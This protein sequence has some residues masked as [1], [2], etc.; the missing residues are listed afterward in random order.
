MRRLASSLLVAVAACLGAL[1]CHRETSPEPAPPADPEV[2]AVYADGSVAPEDRR[3]VAPQG[4]QRKI[5]AADVDR[6][7]LAIPAGQ[8]RLAERKTAQWYEELIRRLV[9]DRLLVEEAK[10]IGIHEEPEFLAMRDE[11]RRQVV[12]DAYLAS[13]RP[14]PEPITG[15]DLRRYFEEHRSDYAQ[16]RRR[17]VRHLFRR[18]DDGASLVQLKQEA[19]EL[20]QRVLAGES[21]GQLAREH[22]DSES[23]HNEGTLGWVTPGT[24]P[25][26]LDEVLF[27]LPERVPSEPL[28]TAEGV[29]L[30]LV[31]KAV[32]AK[33]YS[34]DE[35][36]TLILRELETERDDQ[37]MARLV[38][39]MPLPEGSF[40]AGPEELQS[41]LRAGDPRAA[42]LRSGDYELQLGRF[43]QLAADRRAAAGAQAP[44]DLARQLLTFLERRERIYLHA[45]ARGLGDDPGVSARLAE[46]EDQDLIVFYRQRVLERKLS[47]EPE[48]LQTYYEH[49]RMR[50]A[51]PLRLHL[52]RLTV[53]L[54]AADP[55]A[56]MARLERAHSELDRGAVT[57]EALAAE[58]GGRTEEPQWLT[59]RQLARLGERAARLAVDLKAGDHSPPYQAGSSLELLEVL[60]RREPEP[61]PLARVQDQVRAAYLEDH[62]QELYRDWR[63][64]VLAETG[65]VIYRDRLDAL[66]GR[67]LPPPV[68]RP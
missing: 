28:P 52:R 11:T 36:E 31:E 7:V 9:S 22:S 20:R 29:H 15:D 25:P 14:Q 58:L 26:A 43:H 67:G 60:E 4:R 59:L 63:E 6:A 16:S 49:H 35:V 64:G 37:A 42:V 45:N 46:L 19:A 53:P 44:P 2:L 41:L 56:V 62:R 23:R 68:T 32:E 33:E 18:R 65:F 8:G 17:L 39:D 66:A 10:L 40:V 51:S 47:R 48:R 57:L 3:N 61:R 55:G 38:A 30:F 34:L 1:A 13:N 12:M 27:A 24:F 54:P 50:F 21:F 5:S